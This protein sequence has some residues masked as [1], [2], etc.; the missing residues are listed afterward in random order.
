MRIKREEPGLAEQSGAI[1]IG[2][3]FLRFPSDGSTNW[4]LIDRAERVRHEGAARGEYL[5]VIAA[6]RDKLID[7][8]AQHLF[9][10]RHRNV[11]VEAQIDDRVFRDFIEFFEQQHICKKR[12]HARFEAR[13]GNHVSRNSI[14]LCR[15]V[16]IALCGG[17]QQHVIWCCVPKQEAEPCGAR[18]II[19]A[20]AA[21][22]HRIGFGGFSDIAETWADFLARGEGV[23]QAQVDARAAAVSLADPG[24]LFFSSDS[25][26]KPK[27]VLSSHRA[28][29]LQLWRWRRFN[30][31]GAD[32]R[33]WSAN[34]FFWSGNFCM[35]LGGALTPGGS[36]VLQKTF[37][38]EGALALMEAE[39]VT[40]V[41]AWLAAPICSTGGGTE[42]AQCGPFGAALCQHKLCVRQASD[43]ED[44][45]AGVMARLW[46]HRD[47]HDQFDLRFMHAG[48]AD[49]G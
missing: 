7:D 32:A 29:C 8:G 3:K 22:V 10:Q 15:I 19:D 24:V 6:A 26:A 2:R 47:V 41:F 28:V 38:P 14:K 33:A 45:M 11:A 4:H 18:I 39:R 35:A 9:G 37:D 46:Q 1:V 43:G 49:R 30:Q 27:G 34:G 17:L 13:R 21:G 5:T 16:E 40:M 12:A 23:G 31:S 20:Q 48:G 36:L 44:R 42:L 25:T